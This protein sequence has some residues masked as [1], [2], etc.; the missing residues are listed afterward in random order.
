MC[1]SD[2]GK[3]PTPLSQTRIS[4]SPRSRSTHVMRVA[5]PSS[6]FSTSSLITEGTSLI[7]WPALILRAKPASSARITVAAMAVVDEAMRGKRR[8]LGR[9]PPSGRGEMG[10][11]DWD[12][13]SSP[14]S[15][16]RSLEGRLGRHTN[17]HAHLRSLGFGVLS[18]GG[19]SH[20]LAPCH[21]H[22]HHH[23]DV[24]SQGC[25]NGRPHILSAHV[26]KACHVAWR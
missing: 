22:V 23:D 19:R 5:P 6:A 7:T 20:V 15:Q 1:I 18:R 2:A 24:G 8:E 11:S 17:K 4:A 9:A 14:G 21:P 25:R 26:Q 10:N 3:M 13:N 16:A 12:A